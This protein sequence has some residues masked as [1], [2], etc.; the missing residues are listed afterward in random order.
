MARCGASDHCAMWAD[1]GAMRATHPKRT[2]WPLGITLVLFITPRSSN[3]HWPKKNGLLLS[4]SPLILM[5]LLINCLR[6]KIGL[7]LR[8]GLNNHLININYHQKIFI[9][10]FS[11]QSSNINQHIHYPDMTF[12]NICHS[13]L[14]CKSTPTPWFVLEK[15]NKSFVRIVVFLTK[16][17]SKNAL[18]FS[19]WI[20]FQ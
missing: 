16:N 3:H 7:D 5:F 17:L 6:L 10:V 2:S 1:M 8:S 13:F 11:I 19:H 9:S 15:N 12:G 20:D 4:Q 18:I 14:R